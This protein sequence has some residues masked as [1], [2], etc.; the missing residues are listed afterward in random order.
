MI[1]DGKSV[2]VR[3]PGMKD[4]PLPTHYE[5]LECPVPT[6]CTAPSRTR[7]PR[8]GSGRT[9]IWP[10]G[11]PRFPYAFTT[12]RLTEHHSAARRPAWCR[13]RRSFSRK[14][15]RRS[16]PTGRGSWASHNL[17]WVVI[18]TAARRDRDQSPG[19]RPAAAVPSCDGG[20][21][22]LPDRHA[23]AFRLERL[24]DRRHRERADGDRR[25]SQYQHA[26]KQGVDLQP[27]PGTPPAC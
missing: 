6:P 13:S 26:R 17:D 25:R 16:R 22:R 4:G 15:S 1:A 18:S 20:P 7:S 3:A 12:Y 8:A 5:P 21:H 27:A 2:A 14:A 24:C 23:L 9:T 10:V 19:H 11:D